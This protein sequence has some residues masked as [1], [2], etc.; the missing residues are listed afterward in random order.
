MDAFRD[1]LNGRFGWSDPLGY[2]RRR[3]TILPDWVLKQRSEALRNGGESL[4][5][6]EVAALV[7]FFAENGARNRHDILANVE[8]KMGGLQIVGFDAQSV[9]IFDPKAQRPIPISGYWMSKGFDDEKPFLGMSEAD[10]RAERVAKLE[11]A[12]R[13]LLECMNKRA[14]MHAKIY[15]HPPEPVPDPEDILAGPGLPLPSCHP[16]YTPGVRHGKITEPYGTRIGRTPQA[17]RTGAGVADLGAGG[18]GQRAEYKTEGAGGLAGENEAVAPVPQPD[19]DPRTLLAGL[20][21]HF[22]MMADRFRDKHAAGLLL[23]ELERQ[24]LERFKRVAKRLEIINERTKHT[25]A[26]R[27]RIEASTDEDFVLGGP[28][29]AHDRA[30]GEAEGRRP[31]QG[32]HAGGGIDRRSI[33]SVHRKDRE[34]DG[35]LR[36]GQ[37]NLR[38]SPTP[39]GRTEET[40]RQRGGDPRSTWSTIG[41]MTAAPSRVDLIRRVL[42]LKDRANIRPRISFIHHEGKEWLRFDTDDGHV[43]YD[44]ETSLDFDI[45]GR[46][47]SLR[48]EPEPG[49]SDNDNDIDDGPG[50]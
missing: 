26:K 35:H 1:T 12:P 27:S 33:G 34:G 15:R 20:K 29:A 45:D 31:A 32:V 44:G 21:R 16:E 6:S 7:E 36:S 25:S 28:L 41:E 9:T 43:L 5:S 30:D 10:Y 46:P 3:K 39:A 47:Q 50:F 40:E 17:A 2:E 22:K 38:A 42:S 49:P 23:V 24:G 11:S 8:A 19:F 13:K 14:A 48:A 4:Q 37:G 18:S